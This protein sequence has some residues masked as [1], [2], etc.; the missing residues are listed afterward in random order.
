M[1]YNSKEG[2]E[3]T[4]SST[5]ISNIRILKI[6]DSLNTFREDISNAFRHQTCLSKALYGCKLCIQYAGIEC[7]LAKTGR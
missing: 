3:D 4:I 5:A 1:L 6:S 7:G 2:K